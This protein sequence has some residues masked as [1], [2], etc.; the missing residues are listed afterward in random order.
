MRVSVEKSDTL[1]PLVH[2]GVGVSQVLPIVVMA[3]I[4]PPDSI[5]IFEQPELHLHPKVQTRLGDFL[6]SV[7]CSGKQCIVETHSEYLINRL[8]LRSAEDET[9]AL[10]NVFSLYYVSKDNGSTRYTRIAINEYG[11]IPEW[12][13]GF[14]DESPRE[15][16]RILRAALKKRAARKGMRHD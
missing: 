6:L 3:L 1:H 15:A 11:A 2:V 10:A 14:F 7:A 5:L 8:R 9:D 13:D 12:P 4:A 16:E